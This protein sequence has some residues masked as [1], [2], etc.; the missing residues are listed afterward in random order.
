VYRAKSLRVRLAT[1]WFLLFEI[2]LMALEIVKW[3]L[4]FKSAFIHFVSYFI[5]IRE[6]RSNLGL[7]KVSG[8]FNNSTLS[9]V[10]TK[11]AMFLLIKGLCFVTCLRM[12]SY[13]ILKSWTFVFMLGT[14][15]VYF[16]PFA[17]R[18]HL[19]SCLSRMRLKEEENK[20][21]KCKELES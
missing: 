14:G 6:R 4:L 16:Q 19:H 12:I 20:N 18:S 11:V 2:F 21:P 1:T 3:H 17:F 10:C 7:L 15:T 5:D 13:F 9:A 8:I